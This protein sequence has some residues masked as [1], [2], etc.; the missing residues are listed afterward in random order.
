[1]AVAVSMSGTY[2]YQSTWIHTHV[3]QI[4]SKS[5]RLGGGAPVDLPPGLELAIITAS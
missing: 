1:M 2:R 3:M 4:Q 5:F